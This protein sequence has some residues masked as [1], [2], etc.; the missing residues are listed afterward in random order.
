[1]DGV[2]CDVGCLVDGVDGLEEFVAGAAYRVGCDGTGRGELGDWAGVTAVVGG[3]SIRGDAW[4]GVS[5]G[6][7]DGFGE[8]VGDPVEVGGVDGEVPL[9]C[10]VA[11]HRVSLDRFDLDGMAV[12]VRI[13][14]FIG[15]SLQFLRY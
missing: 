2:A 5:L 15:K 10:G 13:D 9:A 12:A 7:F 11:T 8:V 6:A 1:M 4:M 14:A 3:R